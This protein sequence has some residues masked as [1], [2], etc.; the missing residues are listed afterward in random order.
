MAKARLRYAGL[1]GHP[2][3]HSLSPLMHQAAFDALGIEARYVLWDTPPKRLSE[4]IEALRG[5]DIL[6]A[7][8][9]IPYKSAVLPLLD[10]VAPE[11]KRHAGAVNTIVREETNGRVRLVGYNTDVIALQRVLREH[12]PLRSGASVLVLGAGGAAQAALGVTMLEGGTPWVAARRVKAA[13]AA[14]DALWQREHS[15]PAGESAPPE[16]RARALD[17]EDLATLEQTLAQT[18]ILINATPVGTRDPEAI[19]LPPAVLRQLP[20]SAFV[21]DM[22]YNPPATALVRAAR[23]IGRRATGGLT[24]LLY[25]GAEAFTLWTHQEAPLRVMRAALGLE[26]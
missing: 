15:A 20:A 11:S 5:P 8:V 16:W 4:R 26:T 18:D 7:N 25:Q 1:I 2:V 3:G 13:R 9:T 6:G 10:V 19:P 17:L 23:S 24:M 14:L 22:V 12:A 21:L